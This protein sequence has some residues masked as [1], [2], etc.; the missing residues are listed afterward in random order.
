M[1]MR[2]HW[3]GKLGQYTHGGGGKLLWLHYQ[4]VIYV[5]ICVFGAASLVEGGKL[6]NG[7]G[8]KLRTVAKEG[9]R[10][11]ESSIPA[12]EPPTIRLLGG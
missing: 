2:K 5:A 10:G 6:I 11:G 8:I 1:G 9:C 3:M 4:A 7:V 12:R